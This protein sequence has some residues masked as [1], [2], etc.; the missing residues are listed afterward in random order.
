MIVANRHLLMPFFFESVPKSLY[1]GKPNEKARSKGPL[2]RSKSKRGSK[3]EMQGKAICSRMRI[4]RRIQL[5]CKIQFYGRM[6]STD[7]DKLGL[8]PF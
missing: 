6:A 8:R 2:G 1:G 4:C 5:C 3:K 7:E